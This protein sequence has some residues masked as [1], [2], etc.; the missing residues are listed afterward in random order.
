MAQSI[1]I[2]TLTQIDSAEQLEQ[3]PPDSVSEVILAHKRLSRFGKLETEP[4]LEL[5]EQA[6]KRDLSVYLQWDLLATENDFQQMLQ[7]VLEQIPLSSFGAIR[8]QDIGALEWLR[9]HPAKPKMHW[10]AETGHHNLPSLQRWTSYVGSALERIVLSTEL[11]LPILSEYCRELSVS[12]ELLAVG[13]ILLF[14]SPRKLL[15]PVLGS[16]TE[17]TL[18]TVTST[19]QHHHEFPVL[20]H[21]H[22]TLMFH[23]RDLFLLDRIEDLRSSGLR[24]L[25]FDIQHMEPQVW[26][27]QLQQVVRE[28]WDL[29]GKQIR[30]SWPRQTTHGFF[31]ANRTERPIKKL[32]NPNLHYLDGEVVGYILEVA[33][34]E[35]MVVASRRS[36]AQ[37]DKMILITPE[38]KRITFLVENLRNWKQQEVEVAEARG[39]WLLPHERSATAKSL[40]YFAEFF[41]D[42][43]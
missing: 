34:R 42:G 24:H 1:M 26:L 11:P 28:G 39:L 8:V 19:D 14:Y 15:S 33:S 5:A 27:P 13:R 23:H 30:S 16:P 17:I 10:I 29:D 4:L 20:E 6:C 25:R 2:Q 41:S 3:L 9:Q 18:A 37:G 43:D 12:C 38:G 31:R 32:K 36:F 40:L 35:Y 22:G 21:Q 7:E